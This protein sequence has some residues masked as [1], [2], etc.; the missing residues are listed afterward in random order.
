MADDMRDY[1][2]RLKV[3]V[4]TPVLKLRQEKCNSCKYKGSNNFCQVNYSY[5][6][7]VQKYRYH[8]CPKKFWV[9]QF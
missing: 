4:Q 5:L 6:P 9:E 3:L 1:E 8:A 2:D 7:E